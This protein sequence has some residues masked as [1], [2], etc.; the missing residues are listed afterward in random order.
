MLFFGVDDRSVFE[1]LLVSLEATKTRDSTLDRLGRHTSG[2]PPFF[3]FLT[4]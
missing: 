4:D 1:K 2:S 3:L